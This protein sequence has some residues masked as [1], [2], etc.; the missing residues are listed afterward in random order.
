MIVPLKTGDPLCDR[1]AFGTGRLARGN[2]ANAEETIRRAYDLG[3]RHFDSSIAYDHGAAHAALGR[4]IRSVANDTLYIS[5]KIGLFGEAFPRSSELYRDAGAIRGV[6]HECYRTLEG[7]IDLLQI[8]EAD[9][10]LWWV[11]DPNVHNGRYVAPVSNVIPGPSPVLEVLDEARHNG[12][13]SSIGVTANTARPLAEVVR[14]IA[15]DSVMCAYNLDP[16]FRGAQEFV[17]P[18]ARENGASL[19]AAGILQGGS[20]LRRDRVDARLTDWALFPQR[21][22]AFDHIVAGSGL[23][24]LELLLRWALSVEGVD[25]WVLGASE[26]REIMETMAILRRGPL[27]AELQAAMDGLAAPGIESGVGATRWLAKLD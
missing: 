15:V 25:R 14:H 12:I 6:V 26:P 4:L 24:A 22:D 13:C 5:T 21:L 18:A 10:V 2:L 19:L 27:S 20:Y 9:D 17:L 1:L 16:V 23:S 11:D 8:H 7:K 3:I